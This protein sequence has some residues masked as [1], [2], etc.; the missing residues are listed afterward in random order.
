M[1]NARNIIFALP[2][3]LLI[4]ACATGPKA[5]DSA[6]SGAQAQLSQVTASY[7]DRVGSVAVEQMKGTT[8]PADSKWENL[9]WS[10]I[11]PLASACVKAKDWLKV[12]KMGDWMAR[13]AHL[14]PWGPYYL[15]LSAESRRDYPRAVWMLELALKKAPKE[16]IFHYELGRIHWELKEDAEA[17]KHMRLASEL[18]PTLTGAHWVLGQLAMQRGDNAEAEKY[19]QKAL[20]SDP[21]HAPSLLVMAQL[22]MNAKE[23]DRAETYLMRAISANPRSAKA[24]LALAQVQEQHL[25]KFEEALRSYRQLKQLAAERKLDEGVQLNLDEKIQTLKKSLTQVS[26]AGKV[27]QRRPSAEGKV[28]E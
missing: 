17:I 14:T 2:I 7:S 6:D 12:E 24:R 8:C 13:N 10:K 26:E 18:N 20:S 23:W 1:M 15:A 5:A 11:V 16:G 9:T 22:K 3:A 21:E 25:R 28:H 27:S 4:S 19:L